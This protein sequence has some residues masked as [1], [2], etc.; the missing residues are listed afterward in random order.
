MQ[1]RPDRFFL[2]ELI[3]IIVEEKLDHKFI[4]STGTLSTSSKFLIIKLKPTKRHN[5]HIQFIQF[6]QCFH[7]N[8]CSQNVVS[9]SHF[10]LLHLKL[11]LEDPTMQNISFCHLLSGLKLLIKWSSLLTLVSRC[12]ALQ[13]P[14]MTLLLHFIF[15]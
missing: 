15:S 4:K 11:Y 5:Q 13:S 7:K 10:L 14:F 8:A 2:L 3:N 9:H 6:K 12:D 1:R